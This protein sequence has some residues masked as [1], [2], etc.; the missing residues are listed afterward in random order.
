MVKSFVAQEKAPTGTPS[1]AVE[2]VTKQVTNNNSVNITI[3][4][5]ETP[6]AS[7][8]TI[9]EKVT[10]E[11]ATKGIAAKINWTTDEKLIPIKMLKNNSAILL[12]DSNK[13][14]G[15]KT[16]IATLD[17]RKKVSEQVAGSDN[18]TEVPESI[19]IKGIMEAMNTKKNVTINTLP[20]SSIVFPAGWKERSFFY[21]PGDSQDPNAK[22]Y[23]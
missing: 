22:N 20:D 6:A 11:L 8:N 13:N 1:T 23:R 21:K 17:T 9:A 2:Q 10:E 3:H 7:L 4:G 15:C 18:A 16:V 5:I 12:T 19:I 14:F